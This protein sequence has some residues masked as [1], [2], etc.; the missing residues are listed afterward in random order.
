MPDEGALDADNAAHGSNTPTNAPK[1]ANILDSPALSTL[2]CAFAAA[3]NSP[4][5]TEQSFSVNF[6]QI[7]LAVMADQTA[8]RTSLER[9]H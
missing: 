1:T 6:T 9:Q 7:M 2:H 3:A 4:G 8:L 5:G